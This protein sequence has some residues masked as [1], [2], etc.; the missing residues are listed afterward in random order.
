M[1][2]G[3]ILPANNVPLCSAESLCRGDALPARDVQTRLWVPF[4]VK[5]GSA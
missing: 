1:R 3:E 4:D 2:V 5:S